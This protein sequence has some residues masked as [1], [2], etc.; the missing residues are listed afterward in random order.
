MDTCTIKFE[1]KLSS[2][3]SLCE[4]MTARDIIHAINRQRRSQ[5]LAPV[6]PNDS[7]DIAA[8]IQAKQMAKTGQFGH[9]LRG[10]RY[11]KPADRM[12]ASG[13]NYANAGEVLYS[14]ID[15]PEMAVRLWMGSKPHRIAILHPDVEEV[16]ASVERAND[17]KSY[18]CVVLCIPSDDGKAAEIGSEI[19]DTVKKYG[20]V[21]GKR[22][23]VQ[24]AQSEY[25]QS[26][27]KA[28]IIQRIIA[29][30]K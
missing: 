3:L 14:G 13:Y 24:M 9:N 26:V 17:G 11:P 29:A 23:L 8:E 21:A 28:P 2:T 20:K 27:I 18:V 4:S 19:L 1:H 30:L 5:K 12:R 25:M 6:R 7:I 10:V 15:D 16:G 22:L